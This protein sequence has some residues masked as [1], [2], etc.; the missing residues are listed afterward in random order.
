MSSGH[1]LIVG[2]TES[3]KSSLARA[4]AREYALAG[5]VPIVLDVTRNKEWGA[6][7]IIFTDPDE[8]LRYVRDPQKCLRQP[9]FVEEAGIAVNKYQ[10]EFQW[11][12]TFSR[13]HGMRCHIVAQRAEMVDKT[14][15]SQCANLAAFG[16]PFDDAKAYARE[17]NGQEIMQCTTFRP[18][19]YIHKT[20]YAPGV[21]R[22][23]F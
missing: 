12:T 8:M 11:L 16:L 15:R 4:L 3:G 1:W 21:V 13:H 23:L 2:M 5:H 19:T 17:F 14:T 10:S 22:K 20:R 18:G 7:A 9:I 6:N